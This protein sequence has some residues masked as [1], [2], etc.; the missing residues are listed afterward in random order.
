MMTSLRYYFAGTL[1]STHG[2]VLGSDEGIKIISIDGKVLGTTL[3]NVYVRTLGFGVG[4][5]MGY[6][7]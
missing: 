3:V 6:L 7:G 1:G 2:K 5:D 4:T